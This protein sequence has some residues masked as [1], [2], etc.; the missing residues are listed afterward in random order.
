MMNVIEKG[1][2]NYE[3]TIQKFDR[4]IE[5][6]N[7]S[8]KTF[9]EVIQY[10]LDL[11]NK[12]IHLSAH[13]SRQL[14]DSDMQDLISKILPII[15][16]R[17]S[18]QFTVMMVYHPIEMCWTEEMDIVNV[19]LNEVNLTH[20]RASFSIKRMDE[21]IE[22]MKLNLDIPLIDISDDLTNQLEINENNQFKTYID[23][24]NGRYDLQSHTLKT[25]KPSD[26]AIHQLNYNVAETYD[27]DKF[28][29]IFDQYY[30]GISNDNVDREK[31]LKQLSF[32]VLLNYNPSKKAI[33]FYGKA[34][35][36]KSTF[37]KVLSFLA[38]GKVLT[39]TYNE[40]SENDALTEIK[41]NRL[42]IGY[43]NNDRVSINKGLSVFKSLVTKEPFSYSVKYKARQSNIFK[44]LMLQAFND[45]PE[46]STK[47]S[48]QPIADRMLLLEFNARFR[49]TDNEIEDHEEF[50]KKPD[51]LAQLPLYLNDEVDAFTEFCYDDKET[52]DELLKQSDSVYQFVQHC[53]NTDGVLSNEMIPMSHVYLSYV[54]YMN[55]TD[56]YA[57]KVTK[58]VFNSR[59][60]DHLF[61][62]GYQYYSFNSK[63]KDENKMTMTPKSAIKKDKYKPDTLFDEYFNTESLPNHY[64][65]WFIKDLIP[66]ID[67]I[68]SQGDALLIAKNVY[69]DKKQDVY[70]HAKQFNLE[71]DIKECDTIDQMKNC[72]EEAVEDAKRLDAIEESS[73]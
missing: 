31:C 51:V 7:Q 22:L 47:S 73:N 62:L 20:D 69:G 64:T 5:R 15:K 25:L 50:F 6:I 27:R 18:M 58:K 33:N 56:P 2:L 23:F 1:D 14:N 39:F 71:A 40:L 54:E 12:A 57:K 59:M 49:N 42:L 29:P 44:G 11:I 53:V 67:D 24:K 36:G 8:Y 60:Q 4:K 38:G 52:K 19:I 10:E 43:D 41:D 16:V 48:K 35:G 72:L 55:Q 13:Q 32:A 46:F 45:M 66:D 26:L 37:L 30:A 65:S 28:K 63:K 61:E 34:G 9:R 17:K 68:A 3:D 21:I 70:L